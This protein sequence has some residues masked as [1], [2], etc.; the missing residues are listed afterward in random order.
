MQIRFRDPLVAIAATGHRVSVWQP[1][2]DE[3]RP[4]QDPRGVIFPRPDGDVIVPWAEI[5]FLKED[6]NVD[7][8]P[9]NLD[10]PAVTIR[11]SK[12]RG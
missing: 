11:P 4:V 3:A 2:D 5:Q 12:R 7:A 8:A 6:P 10:E 1:R 9:Q